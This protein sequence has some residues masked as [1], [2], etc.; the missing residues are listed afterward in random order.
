[1]FGPNWLNDKSSDVNGRE[2]RIVTNKSASS[3]EHERL[4]WEI[5][6]MFIPLFTIFYYNINKMGKGGSALT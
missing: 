2:G 6:L 1:M 5:E 3:G 4:R